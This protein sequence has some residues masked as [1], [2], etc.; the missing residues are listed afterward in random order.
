M[1]GKLIF[2]NGDVYEGEFEKDLPH[3]EGKYFFSNGSVYE[4]EFAKGHLHGHGQ[5]H[6]QEVRRPCQR[7]PTPVCLPCASRVCLACIHGVC[8]PWSGATEAGGNW[9]WARLCLRTAAVPA[10]ARVHSG[11]AAAAVVV[12]V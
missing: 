8:M 6:F 12:V 7:L 1:Q 9:D 11:P 10:N 4:G 3:G 5:F 2:P